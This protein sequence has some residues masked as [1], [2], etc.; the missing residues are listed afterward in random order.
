MRAEL[1][2][3]M[4][5]E[6]SA[7]SG[8]STNALYSS[9]WAQYDKLAFLV[10]VI[11]ASKIRDTLKRINLQEDENEKEVGGTP[12]AKRKTNESATTKMS[13]FSFYV[14]EKLSQLDKGDRRIAEKRISDILFETE[15]SADFAIL[16]LRHLQK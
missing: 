13:T 5:I 14:A 15:M 10:P 16:L 8:Q 2:R 12:V 6:K 1:V 4:A 9:N 3:E 11:G 7:K